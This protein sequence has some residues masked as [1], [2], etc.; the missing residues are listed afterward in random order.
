MGMTKRRRDSSDAIV[1]GD[2]CKHAPATGLPLVVTVSSAPVTI[3]VQLIPEG[4]VMRG[5]VM[6]V[7]CRCGRIGQFDDTVAGGVRWASEVG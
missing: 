3:G 1:E 4:V 2:G 5:S 7:Q 6:L